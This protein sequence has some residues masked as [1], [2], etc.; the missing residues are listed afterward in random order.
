MRTN[1]ISRLAVVAATAVLL[2]GS[3]AGIAAA[4]KTKQIS[5]FGSGTCLDLTSYAT[6]TPVTLWPCTGAASQF[7]V[8]SDDNLTI[9]NLVSGMCMDVSS[10]NTGA[11]VHMR[12]CHGGTSQQWQEWINDTISPQGRGDMCMDL[13]SYADRTPVTLA[14]CRDFWLSQK[15]TF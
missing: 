14:P 12:P 11:V 3:T 7:W 1:I 13:K 9:R 10:Y 15:W 4:A 2:I 6:G 8:R 5:N